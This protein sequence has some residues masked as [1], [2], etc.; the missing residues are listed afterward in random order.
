MRKT[1][2]ETILKYSRSNPVP[3]L[4]TGDLGYSVLEEFQI[5]HPDNFINVGHINNRTII[6]S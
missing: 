4:I 3:Y 6:F 1:F 2:I 5:A